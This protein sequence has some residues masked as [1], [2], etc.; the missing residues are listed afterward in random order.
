[1]VFVIH[2]LVYN[3]FKINMLIL[4]HFFQAFK[5]WKC[6]PSCTYNKYVV[7]EVFESNFDSQLY[8]GVEHDGANFEV[9]LFSIH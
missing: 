6:V 3:T 9:V 2:F 1:M 7:R 5:K 4:T 8:H